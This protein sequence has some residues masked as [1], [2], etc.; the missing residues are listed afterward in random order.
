MVYNTEVSRSCSREANNMIVDHPRLSSIQGLKILTSVI[1]LF[2]SS[3]KPLILPHH[4]R[5]RPFLLTCVL[6][7]GHLGSS[8][9]SASMILM[10][11]VAI[12]FGMCRS[13]RKGGS[14]GSVTVGKGGFLEQAALRGPE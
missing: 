14:S 4:K 3:E 13:G 10:R 6:Q 1:V 8:A 11:I 12:E 5:F 9:T 7:Y 2:A